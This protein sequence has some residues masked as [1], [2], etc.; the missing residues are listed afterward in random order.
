V[1]EVKKFAIGFGLAV[2]VVLGGYFVFVR[3]CNVIAAEGDLKRCRCLGKV[4]NLKQ[5][6]G[7]EDAME[8]PKT[9]HCVGVVRK[10][11]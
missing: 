1:Q 11:F 10:R 8:L 9:E 7:S 4:V 3:E 2:A 6:L 5:L